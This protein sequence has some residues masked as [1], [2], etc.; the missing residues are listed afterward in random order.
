MFND[1]MLDHLVEWA[2]RLITG[3]VHTLYLTC[4]GF[5]LALLAALCLQYLGSRPHVLPRL[6]ARCYINFARGVPVLV[7]L[8][9]LYFA[10]P[11]LGLALPS[12]LAGM[13]GLGGVY[14]AYIA[15]V[16]RAG[17]G[18]VPPGQREAAIAAGMTPLQA[19]RLILLPQA[20]RHTLAPL[21][22]NAV[23]LLK[24]SSICALITVPEL[25]LAS[26]EIMSETFLPMQVFFLTA[27]IYFSLAWPAS[28]AVRHMERR[29]QQPAWRAP[30]AAVGSFRRAV[31][32]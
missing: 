21:L 1:L 17:L 14:A 18:A 29:L 28:L 19:F 2:P 32:F 12:Q 20:V 22:I 15:E 16:F 23:S 6:V 30:G 9:L 3:L 31:S 4:G 11:A 27:L 26:R 24:D 8:Y 13:V 10:L 25:T 5:I 7:V